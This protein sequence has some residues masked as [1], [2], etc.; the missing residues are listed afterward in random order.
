MEDKNKG[1]E[2][3]PSVEEII[4]PFLAE[5]N[6]GEPGT[7]PKSEDGDGGDDEV[8]ATI[9]SAIAPIQA[10]LQQSERKVEIDQ[11]FQTELG[12]HLKPYEAKIKEFAMDKRAK[13]MSV[14]AVANA[15]AG[16]ALLNI[17]AKIAEE[18]KRKA[19]EQSTT[20]NSQGAPT[21]NEQGNIPDVS[22]MSR[23]D[24]SNFIER[25]KSGQV[26]FK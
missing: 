4:N 25:A 5:P 26:K 13:G 22:T 6:D 19:G 15:V 18:Q 23:A 9:N 16:K 11:F 20:A 7:D 2:Q 24:F 17:G 21:N 10:K 3:A 12:G 14:E 8:R 1:G